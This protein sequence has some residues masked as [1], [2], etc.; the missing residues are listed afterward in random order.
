MLD[1]KSLSNLEVTLV[2]LLLS[3]G[4]TLQPRKFLTRCV[5]CNGQ[6]QSVQ[7]EEKIQTIFESHQAPKC[8]NEEIFEVFQ[9]SDCKQG[10]WWCDR[11]TSSA[12]RVKSQ[13]TK[14]F[15]TC[16]RGGVKV[17]GD[18]AMFDFVDVEEVKSNASQ[19]A[20]E[21][22]L[23]DQRLAVLQWLQEERL[24]NPFGQMQSTYASKDGC[25][26]LPF[27]NVTS[28]FVGEL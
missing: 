8:L 9:C 3:H 2:H 6:I 11:P 5:V 4:V 28:D 19:E 12:S 13:A 23:I 7:D 15:K 20:V 22:F 10:Y 27:T 25:E 24:E 16:I 21:S 17:V 18:M 26:I 14:I 1:T